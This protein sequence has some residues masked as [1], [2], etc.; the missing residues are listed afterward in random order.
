MNPAVT[1]TLPQDAL[2]LDP[3]EGRD[4]GARHAGGQGACRHVLHMVYALRSPGTAV[5]QIS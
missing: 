4:Q 3:L 5:K 2:H 1:L